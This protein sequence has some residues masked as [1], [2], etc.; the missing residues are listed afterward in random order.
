MPGCTGVPPIQPAVSRYAYVG[1]RRPP[2]GG[3]LG[4]DQA[5]DREVHVVRSV[6]RRVRTPPWL[7]RVVFLV[8]AV[9]ALSALLPALRDRA[10]IVTELVPAAFPAAATTGAAGVGVM[11]IA[12]SGGLRRGKRR[13]WILATVLDGLTVVLHLMKGLDVEE[14]T[15]SVLL[16]LLLVTSGQ[17]FRARPDPRSSGRLVGV[18]AGGTSV[19]WILGFLWVSVDAGGQVAETSTGDRM[20]QVVLGLV[21]VPGP[22]RFVDA[23]GST[24]ASVALAVLGATVL[25]SAVL[26]ALQPAGGP[27]A[28]TDDE[29]TALRGLL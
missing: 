23:S 13:A 25:L 26:V 4:S 9:T 7:A 27:H 29:A 20:R 22:V 28:L 5:R 18:M 17:Q 6:W 3:R 19:A 11:L 1:G 24:R 2:S 21:G 16:L 10:A 8:G 14:A 12:L 15:L